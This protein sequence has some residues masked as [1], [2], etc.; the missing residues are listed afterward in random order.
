M[1]QPV[2][3]ILREY[4][5][6]AAKAIGK[7]VVERR[8]RVQMLPHCGQNGAVHIRARGINA[9][10]RAKRENQF[11]LQFLGDREQNLVAAQ[12]RRLQLRIQYGDGDEQRHDDRRRGARQDP[13]PAFF[14][15]GAFLQIFLHAMT[16]LPS[17]KCISC[18]AYPAKYSVYPYV[19]TLC[20]LII[21]A[22]TKKIL[23]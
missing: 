5:I 17:T 9:V 12:G 14:Q 2:V 22:F 3:Q 11:R 8:G 23:A 13:A 7:D 1:F 18:I 19:Y 4:R 21:P 10:I 6:S 16:S 15:L 20:M